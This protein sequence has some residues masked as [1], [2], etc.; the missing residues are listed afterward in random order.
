MMRSFLSGWPGM[1]GLGAVLAARLA[2]ADGNQCAVDCAS[3]ADAVVR[4]CMARCPEPSEDPTRP[5]PFQA[6]ALR[7]Q[8]R[9]EK[10]FNECA[11]RCVEP[12][13]L[14]SPS[15]GKSGRVR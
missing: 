8:E 7:C 2:L 3:K 15:K 11:E 6:C 10:K 12:E 5:G 14:E 13:G 9:Q 1:L 4:S